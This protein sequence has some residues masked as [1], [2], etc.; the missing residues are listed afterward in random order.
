MKKRPPWR[1][2][3]HAVM[4]HQA[5]TPFAASEHKYTASGAFLS[6]VICFSFST[7]AA[8]SGVLVGI[9]LVIRDQAQ[10][11]R[12]FDRTLYRA[13][14]SAMDFDNAVMPSFAAA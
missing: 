12:Q 4:R 9:E 3:L 13:M 14:S 6:G 10:G 2:F 5:V 1:A 7:A 11:E 8:C